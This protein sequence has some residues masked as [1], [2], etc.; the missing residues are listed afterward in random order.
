M[1]LRDALRAALQRSLAK[2]WLYL[3]ADAAL[4]PDTP[5]VFVD[6]LFVDEA[7]RRR[8]IGRDLLRAALEWTR[9]KGMSQVVLFRQKSNENAQ[10]LFESIGF[11]P[12]MVEMT[13]DL[14][15]PN[16]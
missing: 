15:P 5:C 4:S 1:A 11:R 3:P 9:S 13:L 2:G 10:R 12:T 14:E 8:G 16:P 7:A 6:D